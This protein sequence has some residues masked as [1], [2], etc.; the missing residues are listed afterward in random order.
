MANVGNP[1][2]VLEMDEVPATARTLGFGVASW[3]IRR[4]EDIAPA[5]E[6]LKGRADA[7]LVHGQVAAIAATGGIPR[8]HL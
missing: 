4:A 3:E 7:D 5:F 1:A 6:A 2:L 8:D